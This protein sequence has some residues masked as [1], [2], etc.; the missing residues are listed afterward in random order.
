MSSEIKDKG[1]SLIEVVLA[2]GIFL[3]TVLVLVG[4]LGPTL[5]SVQEVEKTDEI[6]SVIDSVSSFLNGGG[7]F[8]SDTSSFNLIYQ[9]LSTGGYATIYA[10]RS[11][12]SENSSDIKLTVGFSPSERASNQRISSKL[13]AFDFKNAAGP[14]YRCVLTLKPLIPRA[15]FKDRGPRAFPRYLLVKNWKDYDEGY[16]PLQI[17]IYAETPGPSFTDRLSLKELSLKIPDYTFNTA[18]KR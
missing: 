1:F 10:Y 5:E 13:R 12:I 4:M 9:T 8:G 14:I 17:S 15:D 3:V 6:I 16:L 7:S 2:I 11:F 18:I